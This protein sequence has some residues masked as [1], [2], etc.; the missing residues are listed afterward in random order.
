MQIYNEKIFDLMQDKRRENPLQL[1]DTHK[2]NTADENA[3]LSGTVHV[4]GMSVYRIYSKEEALQLLKQ[5][6]RNRAI[7]ATEF[8][9]E[10]SRSHTILQLFVTVEDADEQG[11]MVLKRSTFSLVDLAGSEKWRSS[12]STS[13]TNLQAEALVQAQMKEMTHINTSLHVLG[14]CVSA[15]IE[16]NR[17]HIPY[18]DSVL[19][20]L[21]QDP[22]G[23]NGR[24]IL[25]ATIHADAGHKDETYSTLQFASRASHIKV[26]L[27][28]NVGIN[29]RAN[30]VEAQR[31]IKVLRAK[32]LELQLLQGGISGVS[33]SREGSV[34]PS[35]R[36]AAE[37]G[38]LSSSHE[39]I[40]CT[41]CMLNDKLIAAL[42][43]KVI[44][45]HKEN[46]ILRSHSA[47]SHSF[48]G[49]HF[50]SPRKPLPL[51]NSL[52]MLSPHPHP[53]SA[54]ASTSNVDWH[55]S[56]MSSVDSHTSPATSVIKKKKG[57]G[58]ASKKTR[59]SGKGDGSAQDPLDAP[60]VKA[61]APLGISAVEGM[62][63]A[64]EPPTLTGSPK[65]L[66]QSV[67][68]TANNKVKAE[69]DN[70]EQPSAEAIL[71]QMDRD[72]ANN[73]NNLRFSDSSIEKALKAANLV[74][75][76]P[77]SGSLSLLN[78]L[79][80]AE[81]DNV[82]VGAE[83]SPK[84]KK[85]KAVKS[86]Q[87]AN[88]PA[89]PVHA[90][91]H[92][93]PSPPKSSAPTQAQK[94]EVQDRSR[95]QLTGPSAPSA[96][97][98]S[99]APVLQYSGSAPSTSYDSQVRTSISD[100]LDPID[101][102]GMKSPPMLRR[103]APKENAATAGAVNLNTSG[104]GYGSAMAGPAG[105]RAPPANPVPAPAPSHA[106]APAPAPIPAAVPTYVPQA[107][108]MLT[109]ARKLI[110]SSNPDAC[111]KHGLEQC[112]LCQMF[113]GGGSKLDEL[114]DNELYGT[115][116]R[117]G[118]GSNY[119][120]Y[121]ATPASVSKPYQAVQNGYYDGN[122]QPEYQP[123]NC[124]ALYQGYQQQP[125]YNVQAVNNPASA[126]VANGERR[127]TKEK[128][129]PSSNQDPPT[130]DS[131]PYGTSNNVYGGGGSYQQPAPI[132]IPP[133]QMQ[134]PQHALQHHHIQQQHHNQQQPWQNQSSDFSPSGIYG[135]TMN[136]LESKQQQMYAHPVT[137]LPQEQ[138][139]HDGPAPQCKLHG[140]SDCLLCQM[141]GID[142]RKSHNAMTSSQQPPPQGPYGTLS[143]NGYQ[144][145]MYIDTQNSYNVPIGAYGGAGS[146]APFK[147]Q[148]QD[149]ISTVD[150]SD[151]LN[152]YGFQSTPGRPQQ[153]GMSFGGPPQALIRQPPPYNNSSVGM[154]G[155]PTGRA[156]QQ[157][158][159]KQQASGSQV[160][161][162]KSI[163]QQR[164]HYQQ[165]DYDALQDEGSV[166]SGYSRQHH[167]QQQQQQQYSAPVVRSNY[168]DAPLSVPKQRSQYGNNVQTVQA[169]RNG[170]APQELDPYHQQMMYPRS[171]SSPLPQV[172]QSIL[173][174]IMNEYEFHPQV[175]AAQA[176][177]HY[178]QGGGGYQQHPSHQ[179]HHQQ[180]HHHGGGGGGRGGNI[181]Y[182]DEQDK[183]DG[184]GEGEGE[185][186]DDT[187]DEHGAGAGAGSGRGGVQAAGTA[188]AVGRTV[189]KKKKKLKKKT[190]RKVTS[191]VTGNPVA[192]GAP[193]GA[194]PKKRA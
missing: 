186:V 91:P 137:S 46:Q 147:L 55:N 64:I 102:D 107:L 122:P 48:D 33:R 160:R 165:S 4:R 71:A 109:P 73:D 175:S 96:K 12:L 184:E 104:V 19:T 52:T 7:R 168:L 124:S 78:L 29:E 178:S 17:K 26:A 123:A 56:S 141:R 32:L 11:L 37:D 42:R 85:K 166:Q 185:E 108:P 68:K 148:Q 155:V 139:Q 10:S 190:T 38:H 173:P 72:Y 116:P 93:C 194:A 144:S 18:R 126:P 180:Q 1:R 86:D 88:T 118:R 20:R 66:P 171:S 193:Y 170:G 62:Q 74:L 63:L 80:S 70:A 117:G 187:E 97:P 53:Q 176:D 15:L 105:I 22:L 41:Q 95:A 101:T 189:I 40:R 39:P 131:N 82:I 28:V 157:L 134:Q 83:K 125:P 142:V 181:T 150:S 3:G 16:P 188:G 44:E 164:Q 151:A 98:V 153:K 81:G 58:S 162:V 65:G 2:D 169:L 103:T 174:S 84:K 36:L 14:N 27:T 30:L 69:G 161:T 99:V 57:P 135:S 167:H 47:G 59:G 94:Q 61:P 136:L 121:G 156:D 45:L 119:V 5:G 133:P 79:S 6:M 13:T 23:G 89:E 111:Q 113:G 54:D 183:D 149:F 90:D 152:G 192:I 114:T 128:H 51:A 145:N 67:S 77:P 110:Q 177:R 24:T 21:L 129:K 50:K 115:S 191:T 87:D 154:S 43:L 76:S 158:A 132:Q 9:N 146:P 182:V 60:Q 130:L 127:K 100:F 143:A 120:P 31:Q 112:V 92:S 179:G 140:V 106:P 49:P 172:Q 25:I 159:P 75:G 34:S 138:M 8:N 163:P 35:P